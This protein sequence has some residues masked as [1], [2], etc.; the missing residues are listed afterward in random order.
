MAALRHAAVIAILAT[1]GCSEDDGPPPPPPAPRA[2]QVAGIIALHE[3][4]S[5]YLTSYRRALRLALQLGEIDRLEHIDTSGTHDAS[6]LLLA[7]VAVDRLFHVIVPLALEAAGMRADAARLR[8]APP[9]EDARGAE[10]ASAQAARLAAVVRRTRSRS[11]PEEAP[12]VLG[13]TEVVLDTARDLAT[14]VAQARGEAAHAEAVGVA[15]ASVL[16]MFPRGEDRAPIVEA[17]I[18][19]LADLASAARGHAAK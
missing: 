11:G 2:S 15:A 19:L 8:R 9:I 12:F 18:Q 13:H 3:N 14:A 4:E 10:V 5:P 17:L 7:T 6:P 16:E 1:V